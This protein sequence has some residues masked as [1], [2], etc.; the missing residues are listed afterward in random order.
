[1][2]ALQIEFTLELEKPILFN[3]D[4]E[5]L[6]PYSKFRDGEDFNNE[7]EMIMVE[8]K[9]YFTKPQ[10][11][12]LTVVRRRAYKVAGVANASYRTYIEDSKEIYGQEISRDTFR[13]ALEKAEERGLLLKHFGQRMVKGRGSKTANVIIFNRYDEVTA[14][15]IA[16][17]KKQDEELARLL[18]EEQ[19]KMAG[20]LNYAYNAR[21]WAE[22]KAQKQAAKE[23]EEARKAAAA[24]EAERQAKL[25]SLQA[26][27][28][29]YLEAK[30]MTTDKTT[31]NEYRK[32]V[33]ST[34]HKAMQKDSKLTRRQAEDLAYEAFVA[35][36]NVPE[37]QVK[38]NRFALLSNKLSRHLLSV[39]GEYS[40]Q[41]LRKKQA[42]ALGA[43][44]ESEPEWMEEHKAEQERRQEKQEQRRTSDSLIDFEAERAKILAKLEQNR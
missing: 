21:R 41:D 12:A 35:M 6:R 23:A 5:M 19:R 31:F 20:V 18:E 29:A 37:S 4:T 24:K 42:E 7:W 10:M 17:A 22:E 2:G 9:K 11:Q 15:A 13:T 3:H 44:T 32:I 38:K 43:R 25:V 14:Y 28:R 40:K 16:H 26:R 8:H 1:M 27:M 34:I 36:C 33:Y 39:V 30:K